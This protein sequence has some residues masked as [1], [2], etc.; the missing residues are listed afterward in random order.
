MA[1]EAER[2]AESES[3]TEAA[4]KNSTDSKDAWMLLMLLYVTRKKLNYLFYATTLLDS[5]IFS[6]SLSGTL[7]LRQRIKREADRLVCVCG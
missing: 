4:D 3:S 5:F 1:L 6:T 7:F 2:D